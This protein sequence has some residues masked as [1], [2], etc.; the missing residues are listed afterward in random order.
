MQSFAGAVALLLGVRAA[1][2]VSVACR[3]SDDIW[4]NRMQIV[5]CWG[6]G[7]LV[8]IGQIEGLKQSVVVAQCS[9]SVDFVCY[10]SGEG[11]DRLV[12]EPEGKQEY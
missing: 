11:R 6:S 12:V 7:G 3:E 10:V 2:V 9:V 8:D 5:E 4:L 1:G